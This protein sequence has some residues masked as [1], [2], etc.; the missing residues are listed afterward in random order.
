MP[1]SQGPRPSRCHRFERAAEGREKKEA[2][3]MTL[4]LGPRRFDVVEI[5]QE[6]HERA[7]VEFRS[8]YSLTSARRSIELLMLEWANR[9]LNLWCCEPGFLPLE[10]DVNTYVLPA[11]TVD[12]LDCAIGS[13]TSSGNWGADIPLVRLGLASWPGLNRALR[14]GEP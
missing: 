5:A 9:G 6:A 1:G 8:G 13:I 14:P 2:E 3:E 4:T 10:A 11:D 7:G 12:L